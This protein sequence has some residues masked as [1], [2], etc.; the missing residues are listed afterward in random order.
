[1]TIKVVGMKIKAKRI[2]INMFNEISVKFNLSRKVNSL[3]IKRHCQR[4]QLKL[5]MFKTSSE[6]KKGLQHKK[7]D[8]TIK[9]MI[10]FILNNL[11]PLIDDRN[12]IVK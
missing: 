1:M 10:V 12:S 2:Q 5:L 4:I 7:G 8:L 3:E 9:I 6:F 11:D